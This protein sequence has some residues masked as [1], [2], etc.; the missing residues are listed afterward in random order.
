MAVFFG[1]HQRSSIMTRLERFFEPVLAAKTRL[2]G[3][4]GRMGQAAQSLTALADQLKALVAGVEPDFLDLGQRLERIYTD[5]T[6]LVEKNRRIIGGISANDANGL[7]V[8]LGGLAKNAM[9]QLDVSQ[10]GVQDN[11]SQ[12]ASVVNRLDVIGKASAEA[13][14]I[15]M[16]LRVVGLN[17]AIEAARSNGSAGMFSTISQELREFSNNVLAIA[18]AIAR[19]SQIARHRLLEAQGRLTKDMLALGTLTGDARKVVEATVEAIAVLMNQAVQSLE[20]A[21]GHGREVSKGVAQVVMGIQ[22]HDSLSQRI[23]HIATAL[24]EAAAGFDGGQAKRIDSQ[25]LANAASVVSLQIAHLEAAVTEIDTVYREQKSAFDTIQAHVVQLT[26]GFTDIRS[27]P[28]ASGKAVG[29]FGALEGAMGELK[30][31]HDRGKALIE[32]FLATTA[33]A[34]RCTER[35]QGKMGDIRSIRMET[36][37]KALNAIISAAHMGQEGRTLEVLAQEIKTL[38]DQAND[39]VTPVTAMIE[40]VS[41]TVSGIR[42]QGQASE[43]RQ[44]PPV[45]VFCIEDGLQ[46]LSVA[47]GAFHADAADGAARVRELET[48]I[49][50]ICRRLEFL[51]TLSRRFAGVLNQLE[52]V[53]T[54][55]APWK[56]KAPAKETSALLERYTMQQE[57]DIHSRFGDAGPTP[58]AKPDHDVELFDDGATLFDVSEAEASPEPALWSQT[59][60]EVHTELEPESLGDNV[61]MF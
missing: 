2:G 29:S 15:G 6:A 25:T 28:E 49:A 17:I 26:E 4:N 8:K 47:L 59:A 12:I 58:E 3:R 37:M 19:E 54:A 41:D 57:R 48:A 21:D 60:A 7:L 35:L 24:D 38:S 20:D 18:E 39:F 11:L 34:S 61:E 10:T 44:P 23:G 14:R 50:D 31:L 22:F 56:R 27:Q 32:T 45:P 30:T 42:G 1:Q 36:R 16:V 52:G 40:A 13:T 5:A 51:S 9:Q 46:E 55:L 53:N 43:P 33:A